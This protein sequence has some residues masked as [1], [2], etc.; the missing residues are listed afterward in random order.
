[1]PKLPRVTGTQL[2]HALER[3]GFVQVRQRGSHV[4]LR[5]T[6]P[7]GRIT[8]FPVPVHSG[9]TIKQGT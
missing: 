6:E 9:K 1:M 7:D 8:T 3:A 5:R 2:V 4:Q